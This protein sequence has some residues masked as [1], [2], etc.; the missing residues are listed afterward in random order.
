MKKYLVS[1]IVAAVALC[2][3]GQPKQQA[4]YRID[5]EIAG[6]TGKVYLTVFEGKQPLRVDSAE[7]VNGA[8]WFSGDRPVP[9]LA[10]VETA[11]VPLVRFFLENSPI[12]ISGSADQPNEIKVTGSETNDLFQQYNFQVDSI[13]KVLDSDTVRLS[14][15]WIASSLEK[16]QDSIGRVF[17]RQHPNSVAAAYVLFRDLSYDMSAA[18]LRQAIQGLEPSIRSSVYVTLLTGMA[19]ALA[20]TEPGQKYIDISVPDTA[21][22][23]LPLS[24]FV[25]EGKYVLLDFWASW[26]PPCRAEVPN[27]AAAYKEYRSRGFEIYAVSLDKTKK[28]WLAGIGSLHMDWP[29]VSSLKF[30]ESPAAETYGVRSIPSNILIGPDGTILAR[31]LM[32]QALLQKLAELMPRPVKE[33][34]A[35]A[36][37]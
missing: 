21:G 11:D 36:A 27:L 3:C 2:S 24:R 10:A 15:T 37:K 19:D 18:Q 16:Q 9:I 4:G 13:R 31:N 30:W 35:D 8:F 32:G 17:V 12:R 29:Q 23:E 22:V 20:K 25:G 14:S 1:S 33:V 5:G 26:C 7:V 28:A 34:S 6:I